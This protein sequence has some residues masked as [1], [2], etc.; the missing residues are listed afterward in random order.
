[1]DGK[2]K[3]YVR[4]DGAIGADNKTEIKIIYVKNEEIRHEKNK[5]DGSENQNV[6]EAMRTSCSP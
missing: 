1:M 5:T 2:K 6:D 3:N 4:F